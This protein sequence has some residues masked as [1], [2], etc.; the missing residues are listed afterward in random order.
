MFQAVA[1]RLAGY[2]QTADYAAADLARRLTEAELALTLEQRNVA[3]IKSTLLKAQE[4]TKAFEQKLAQA[5]REVASTT[6]EKE[7]LRKHYI[8]EVAAIERSAATDRSSA[9]ADA[10]QAAK[11][12]SDA[13]HAAEERLAGSEAASRDARAAETMHASALEAAAR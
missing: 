1:D 9:T 7:V 13:L 10:T 4:D 6:A 2:K 8:A 11:L 3:S 12:S 5:Q